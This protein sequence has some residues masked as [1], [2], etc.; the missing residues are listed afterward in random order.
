VERYIG[1][2]QIILLFEEYTLKS[3]LLYESLRGADYSCI[4]FVIEEND[5]LP[6]E[7]FSIYDL[8]TGDFEKRFVRNPRFFNEIEAPDNWNISAGVKE[9]YGHI[10][11]RHEEKGRIYYAESEKRFSV[12]AVEWY[13]KKGM[14]RFR[15]H[16]NR[17]GI[18]C[19]R[20]FYDGEGKAISKSW[21][22]AEGKEIVVENYVTGDIILNDDN[23]V[24]LF[25]TKIDLIVYCFNKYG[26]G[27]NRIF[28]N[29]LASPFEIANRLQSSGKRDVLFWQESIENEIP[30]GMQMILDGKA[31]RIGKI[32]VRKRDAYD[33]VLKFC[34]K[35]EMI[36]ELGYV[37]SFVKQNNH[38]LAALICTNSE[39]IEHCRELISAFPQ[40]HFHIAALTLMS[41]NLMK[42]EEFNNVSLHPGVSMQ[43]L[44]ELF[45]SCDYYFDINYWNEIASAVYKAFIHN[46]LIFAFQ[47]TVHNREFVA[48]AHIYSISEFESMVMDIK[49]IM[50]NDGVMEQHL[51][52]QREHAMVESKETYA[53]MLD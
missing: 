33:K 53:R 11:Y 49:K 34:E 20:T 6:K 35:R 23:I 32:M 40:M 42:L 46:Q 19:A 39:A 47:E 10:S 17:Y 38:K 24:K 28:F 18:N 27:Q 41:P 43:K 48:D 21:L 12:K 8:I 26:I 22:S 2:N 7:V 9:R 1:S 44:D 15:E 3:Q 52:M 30:R 29:S 51:K 14:P 36:Q 13:D 4:P 50:E 45:H 37:Y 5:F 25:R 16:Y 31:F